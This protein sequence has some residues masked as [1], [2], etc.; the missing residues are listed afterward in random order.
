[1]K[2]TKLVFISLLFILSLI[3]T[4]GCGKKSLQANM[5]PE[6]RMAS[7]MELFDKDDYM[8]AR[9]QFKII[10]LSHSGS[11]IADKAQFYLAECHY[12]LKEYILSASEYERLIKVYPNSEWV[13]DGKFKIGLSYYELSPKYSLDQDYTQKAIKEFQEFLEDYPGSNLFK[14][15]EAML[16]ESRG[17]LARKLYAAADQYRRIRAYEA[18][19]IYFNLVLERYYDS[20]YAPEAQFYLGECYGKLEKNDEALEAYQVFVKRYPDHKLTN[21]AQDRIE[22]LN[23]TNS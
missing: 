21:K 11:V 10:T 9:N 3:F 14:D 23:K 22:D 4:V 2:S 1:M 6:E 15:V 13:D 8:D 12:N 17:K 20:Q 7:A 16:L 19:A 5:P 18:G